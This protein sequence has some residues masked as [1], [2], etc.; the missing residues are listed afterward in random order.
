MIRS[1]EKKSL[2]VLVTRF[3]FSFQGQG[4]WRE[5]ACTMIR[6]FVLFVTI[7][8]LFSSGNSLLQHEE[9]DEEGRAIFVINGATAG[10]GLNATALLP[11]LLISTA[12]F[13]P[14]LL[15]FILLFVILANN[16]N[17]LQNDQYYHQPYSSS[18]SSYR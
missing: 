15:L 11:F 13:L 8:C 10:L 6:R 1:H 5:G 16:N 18:Y 14:L 4:S 12:V 2:K 7:F 17:N 3:D 9:E